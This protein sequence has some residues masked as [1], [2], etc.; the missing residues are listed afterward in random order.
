MHFHER[1]TK[2]G[3]RIRIFAL[4]HGHAVAF[5]HQLQRFEKTD[6]L[7]FHDELKQVATDVAAEA[8]VKLMAGMHRERWCLFGV[9]RAQP[10]VARRAAR[11][12]QA[13]VFFDDFYDVDGCFD[14]LGEIHIRYKRPIVGEALFL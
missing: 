7:D 11:F 6:A 10:G 14:L 3:V 1:A 8:F 9:E 4:R 2:L 13:H 5:G 12:L